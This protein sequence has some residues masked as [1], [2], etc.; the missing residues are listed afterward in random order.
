MSV[1]VLAVAVLGG[2]VLPIHASV[3]TGGAGDDVIVTQET[4]VD[5]SRPSPASATQPAADTRTLETTIAYPTS[6]KRPLP[7]VVL[8]HGAAGNPNKFTQLI[9]AWA[10]AG[11]V[12]VAP[13]FPRT[14]DTCGNLIADF[15]EQP[16]DVSFVLDRVLALAEKRG[17]ELRGRIDP[18][19]IGLAGLSLG[20]FTT[21]GTIFHPCC[22]D[23]RFDAALLMSAVLGSFPD[24]DYE[25][26]EVPTLL[27]HGD[28]DPLYSHS[29]T[30]YPQLVAPKWFVT[31]HGGT[32][33]FPFE[34]FPEASDELVREI[35][36]DFWDR[37]LRGE[38][39]AAKRLEAAVVSSDGLAALQRAAP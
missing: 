35:T 23:D 37:Y 39:R 29:V 26:D 17:S 21:Y 1:V 20:G 36:T 32:H 25:F 6:T 22:A 16:A 7:L 9:D 24:G 13:L 34:D 4:F 5:R 15:V 38:R 27:V 18:E 31:I 10:R 11:Y 14:S 30:A 33:A 12:V 19:R 28:A 3:A 8:A 2:L